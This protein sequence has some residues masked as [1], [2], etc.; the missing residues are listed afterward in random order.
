[1]RARVAGPYS[2]GALGGSGQ[3]GTVTVRDI[4][5]PRIE[6]ALVGWNHRGEKLMSYTFKRTLGEPL[7]Q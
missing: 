5:A 1:M 6:V 2:E 7:G 4:G 3:F